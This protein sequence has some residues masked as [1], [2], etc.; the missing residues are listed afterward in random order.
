VVYYYVESQMERKVK[1]EWVY[2]PL[3]LVVG[4][5]GVLVL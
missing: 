5:F 1:D 4:G 3:L 2:V